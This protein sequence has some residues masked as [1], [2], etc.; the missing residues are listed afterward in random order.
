MRSWQRLSWRCLMKLG[1]LPLR[2]VWRIGIMGYNAK[3]QNVDL[4]IDAFKAGLKRQGK[5]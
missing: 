5:L 3:P 1:L 4:V 2:Q